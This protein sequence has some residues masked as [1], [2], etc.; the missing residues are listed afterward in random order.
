MADK[1][2]TLSQSPHVT[3]LPYQFLSSWSAAI[4]RWVLLRG[5]DAR[6][7]NLAPGLLTSGLNQ[8]ESIMSWGLILHDC[9]RPGEM[10]LAVSL[11]CTVTTDGGSRMKRKKERESK[12]SQ[13]E[14]DRQ[15]GVTISA[16]PVFLFLQWSDVEREGLFVPLNGGSILPLILSAPARAVTAVC[17]QLT[18]ASSPALTQHFIG[19]NS[20]DFLETLDLVLHS[21]L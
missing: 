11:C 17:S 6:C 7:T 19:N 13:R 9:F 15:P 8:P 4:E 1:L 21:V 10:E 18:P 2:K 20:F 16:W 5:T 12:V 14:Q 3:L